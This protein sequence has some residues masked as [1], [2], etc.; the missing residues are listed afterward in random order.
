MKT[1]DN[2]NKTTIPANVKVP[3]VFKCNICGG[4]VDRYDYLFQCRNCKAV[5][6]L[7]TG[8]MIPNIDISLMG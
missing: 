5:G 1:I 6:D 3:N 4:I 8:I 7:I 2:T